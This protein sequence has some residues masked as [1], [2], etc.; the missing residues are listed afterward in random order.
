VPV[1][2]ELIPLVDPDGRSCL[3][4][5]RDQSARRNAIMSAERADQR[6]RL[7]SDVGRIG[8]WDW[9]PATGEL[10]WDRWLRTILGVSDTE[11]PTHDRWTEL[12]NPH[13]RERAAA[14]AQFLIAGALDE[15]EARYRINRSDGTSRQVLA[16]T[17]VTERDTDG[18]AT[19]LI[20]VLLDITELHQAAEEREHLLAAERRARAAA[21]QASKELARLAS[22]DPLT[23]LANRHELNRWITHAL[24]QH[25]LIAV[26]FF[27]I[28]RFKPINDSHGH[29]VGDHVLT[30]L[31]HRL[32]AQIRE[33]DL[34]ARF[35]GDEF[36]IATIITDQ[37]EA[38]QL[39]RRLLAKPITAAGLRLELTAGV[40]LALSDQHDHTDPQAL[41]SDADIALYHAKHHGRNRATWYHPTHRAVIV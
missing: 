30:E 15:V 8:T 40:G 24:T 31:A 20:G 2:V 35:G 23:G 41:L 39:A 4:I 7:A 33:S 25:D 22:S 37:A 29:N 38:T 36:I 21:E 5:L 9:K 16:R 6:L 10:A 12:M 3:V 32:R 13:D 27:D 28:D 34:V 14:E 18:I 17:R 1:E 26:M 19:C 11:T